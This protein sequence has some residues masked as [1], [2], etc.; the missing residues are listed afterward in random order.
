MLLDEKEMG[1][2]L[3][4]FVESCSIFCYCFTQKEVATKCGVRRAGSIYHEAR[5]SSTL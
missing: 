5:R 1:K 4:K 3:M 2:I